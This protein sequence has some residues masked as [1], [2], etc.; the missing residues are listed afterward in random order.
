MV[1]SSAGAGQLGTC[2]LHMWRN[3]PPGRCV[4][5]CEIAVEQSESMISAGS[6]AARCAGDW[7]RAPA[8]R[9]AA[10]SQPSLSVAF[11]CR[12]VRTWI[13]CHRRS[14]S[15]P[16]WF[17]ARSTDWPPDRTSE[18]RARQ[19]CPRVAPI[20]LLRDKFSASTNRSFGGQPESP[21]LFDLV[22][23]MRSQ[24]FPVQTGRRT[25]AAFCASSRQ[26]GCSDAET[27]HGPTRSPNSAIRLP[28]AK[29]PLRLHL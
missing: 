4:A 10:R 19:A 8:L 11:T 15:G 14:F 1:S 28:P 16:A 22:S 25:V 23:S 24:L 7:H 5:M 29:D 18:R 12:C 9:C 17:T 13:A 21:A 20:R 3:W 26:S 27:G 6:A 2:G